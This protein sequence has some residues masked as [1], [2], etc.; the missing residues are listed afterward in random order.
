VLL[1]DGLPLAR[2]LELAQE[3]WKDLETD[4]E[5]IAIPFDIA[6]EDSVGVEKAVAPGFVFYPAFFDQ[7]DQVRLHGKLG[8]IFERSRNIYVNRL[9]N[10]AD[11]LMSFTQGV[12]DLFLPHQSVLDIFSDLCFR[13]P[14]QRPVARQD[15]ADV[16]SEQFFEGAEVIC[17]IAV[18]RPDHGRSE[19][20]DVITAEKHLITGFVKTAV[21]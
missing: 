16:E 10:R 12:Q 3:T 2:S 9:R 14:H 6:R 8:N 19:T 17:H 20:E 13:F 5:S 15:Q 18:R 7:L 1:L 11:G 21:A 4:R